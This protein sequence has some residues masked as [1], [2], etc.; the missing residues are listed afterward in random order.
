MNKPIYMDHA[1]TTPLD[2]RVLEKMT[3]YLTDAPQ[4]E[5][6]A[7]VRSRGE[8]GRGRGAGYDPPSSVALRDITSGDGSG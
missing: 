7:C 4:R 1:A 3:P 8:Q 5:Q 2:P 6:P